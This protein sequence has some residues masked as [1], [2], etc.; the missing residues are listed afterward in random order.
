MN[1]VTNIVGISEIV[2]VYIQ[3]TTTPSDLQRP[4]HLQ[5]K[6]L[7]EAARHMYKV[8]STR[9]RRN[10]HPTTP[11]LSPSA[12]RAASNIGHGAISEENA[13]RLDRSLAN[14][15]TIVSARA[16][17]CRESEPWQKVGER[18]PP[19]PNLAKLLAI[20]DTCGWCGGGADS[21]GRTRHGRGSGEI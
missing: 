14:I 4:L 10:G 15:R 7:R 8:Q 9:T 13:H 1:I 17:F 16:A 5:P 6:T 19:K 20:R 18:R 2:H 11:R 3:T 12:I 21:S